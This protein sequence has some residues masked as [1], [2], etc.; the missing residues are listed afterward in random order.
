MKN[1]KRDLFILAVYI[2]AVVGVL[3]TFKL[4][5]DV[6]KTKTKTELKK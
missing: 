6:S 1:L 4:L 5:I 3:G 2:L